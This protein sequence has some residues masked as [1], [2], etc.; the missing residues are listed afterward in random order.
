MNNREDKMVGKAAV[1]ADSW[2]KL[3]NRARRAANKA[4]RK[5]A[6]LAL[7]R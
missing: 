3:N 7:A 5:A 1:A 2:G 4:S 6:K